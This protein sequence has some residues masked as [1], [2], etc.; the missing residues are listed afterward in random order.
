MLY[1]LK[2]ASFP[3]GSRAEGLAIE[4]GWGHPKADHDMM[5]LCTEHMNFQVTQD[6]FLRDRF[7]IMYH[8]E[9]CRPAYCKLKV[10]RLLALKK[11]LDETFNNLIQSSHGKNWI[12]TF[13]LLTMIQGEV[14]TYDGD[15][16]VDPEIICGPAGQTISGS[17]EYVP[18]LVGSAPYPQMKQFFQQKDKNTCLTTEVV[19]AVSEMAMT[20]VLCGHKA[21]AQYNSEARLS[22][23]LCEFKLIHDQPTVVKQA[24]IAF[25]YI[26]KRILSQQRSGAWE[27]DGRGHMSSYHLKSILLQYLEKTPTHSLTSSFEC[28]MEL[29]IE[30]DSF[31]KAGKLPHYF[32]EQC[33]LF[34]MIMTEE[35]NSI[36]KEIKCIMRNPFSAILD[37]LTEPK[38]IFDDIQPDEIQK[39]LLRVS[40]HPAHI[41]SCH[42]LRTILHRLDAHRLRIFDELVKSDKTK[43][44]LA[45][46]PLTILV[47][48]FD[49]A[50]HML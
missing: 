31:L 13:N 8:P 25:K 39:A 27:N 21:S 18:A 7:Y 32:V 47:D 10:T 29:F 1:D 20:V 23:S 26:V 14:E 2:D 50:M 16:D 34:E 48:I 36:R 17:I 15:D 44:V 19:K 33:D 9:G 3:S 11:A 24:Y 28:M 6:D 22:F 49:Q 42:H 4:D 37:T 35:L 43:N 30:L 5:T 41:W 38:Q 45:R 40:L 46:P 12:N